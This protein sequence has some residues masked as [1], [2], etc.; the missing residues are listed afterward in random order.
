MPQVRD[1][2]NPAL[3]QQALDFWFS[4]FTSARQLIAPPREAVSKWFKRDDEL[5]KACV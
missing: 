2:I 3:L 5:D 4:H 1:L